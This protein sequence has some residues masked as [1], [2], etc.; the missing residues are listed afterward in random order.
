M[1]KLPWT[2]DQEAMSWGNLQVKLGAPLKGVE[3]SYFG[4]KDV[5][6]LEAG[7]L[8]KQ[9]Y[10]RG[11]QEIRSE[12]E[13]QIA[14]LKEQLQFS[15]ER[16]FEQ[17]NG[18]FEHALA[19]LSGRLPELVLSIVQKLWEGIKLTP[20]QVEANVTNFIKQ[21]DIEGE[22]MDLYL[23]EGDLET[24]KGQVPDAFWKKYD[25][26]EFHGDPELRS[27]DCRVKTRFGWVDSTCEAKLKSM[28]AELIE[29]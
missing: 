2:R 18:A 23:S 22:S 26:I 14:Q 9:A 7:A 17:V 13:P 12:L 1:A 24:L 8:E 25:K 28:T 27:G 20:E 3:L 5:R 29:E 21:L 6:K 15:S 10:E 4:E 19:D 16:L 11:R